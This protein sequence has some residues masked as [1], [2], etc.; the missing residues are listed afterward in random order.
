[1]KNRTPHS[2]R[3]IPAALGL[4]FTLMANHSHGA[5][6]YCWDPT[7]VKS[8]GSGGGTATW[9]SANA[10]W[11]NASSDVVWASGNIAYI[12]AASTITL[13]AAETAGG[14]T[15]QNAGSQIN[16]SAT[17]TLN[18]TT[19]IISVPAG[20]P[21]YIQCVLAGSG[22]EVTGGGVLVL[23][24]AG[25]AS[26]SGSSAEYVIG[27]NTCLVITSYH[28]IGNGGVTMN[29]QSGGILQNNDSTSDTALPQ[30]LKRK[31]WKFSADL[32]HGR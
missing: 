19:P 14:I 20:T 32:P 6:T 9:N 12:G 13:G 22:Y 17:L 4:L 1:M 25:N 16:G 28:T 3:F 11:Y 26:G 2:L 18:G 31:D 15:F 8:C 7:S 29:L 23:D 21:T 30:E 27:P 5:N 10:N 24:N